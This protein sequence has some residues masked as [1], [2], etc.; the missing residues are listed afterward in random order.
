MLLI[1]KSTLQISKLS[2]NFV[3]QFKLC[4]LTNASILVPTTTTQ[5]PILT[6]ETTISPFGVVGNHPDHHTLATTL[7]TIH[8]QPQLATTLMPSI[9]NHPDFQNSFQIGHFS[10]SKLIM[11]MHKSLSPFDNKNKGITRNSP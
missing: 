11:Y 6:L 1:I 8:W 2:Q 9:D 4:Q 5:T 7:I 10:F 3:N